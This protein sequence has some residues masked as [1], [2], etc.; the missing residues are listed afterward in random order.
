M[1]C[2]SYSM[3][4]PKIFKNEYVRVHGSCQKIPSPLRVKSIENIFL[5][6]FKYYKLSLF[7]NYEGYL[8]H[9]LI[10]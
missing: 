3:H 2:S 5:I 6:V 1:N 9:S 8:K 4:F 10:L 7:L